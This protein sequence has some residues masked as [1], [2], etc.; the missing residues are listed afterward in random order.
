M[1]HLRCS[2]RLTSNHLATS[3]ITLA[4]IKLLKGIVHTKMKITPWF[5]HAQA[6]IGIYDFLLSDKSMDHYKNKMYKHIKFLIWTF[7]LQKHI[8]S[9][10]EAV[11]HPLEPCQPMWGTFY[12]RWMLFISLILDYWKITPIHFYYKAW[13][14]QDVFKYNSDW[15]R[16]K[17]E[18]HTHLGWIEGD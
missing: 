5:T 2:F 14:S 3:Q 15:I 17:K 6:I 10:Q 12:C 18:S 8:D 11:I 16:M 13:K 9:L 7:F 4:T 1:C